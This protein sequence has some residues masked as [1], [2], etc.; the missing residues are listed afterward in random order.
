MEMICFVSPNLDQPVYRRP[1]PNFFFSGRGR[2]NTDLTSRFTI[3]SPPRTRLATDEIATKNSTRHQQITLKE[4]T[5]FNTQ[6]YLTT[7]FTFSSSLFE[8]EVDPNTNVER[9]SALTFERLKNWQKRFT[10]TSHLF[11]I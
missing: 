2:L 10:N 5:Q 6:D 8:F 3:I 7:I 9:Q 1:L 4:L 11:K